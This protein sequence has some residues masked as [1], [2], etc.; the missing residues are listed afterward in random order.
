MSQTRQFPLLTRRSIVQGSVATGAALGLTGFG[1]RQTNAQTGT[2]AAAGGT[3][4]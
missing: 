2:P 3:P 4:Q 1:L